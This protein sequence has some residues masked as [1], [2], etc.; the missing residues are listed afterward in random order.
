MP[1]ASVEGKCGCGAMIR[2]SAGWQ[3]GYAADCNSAY[4]GSIPTPASNPH[5][6]LG[7]SAA[8]QRIA[9]ATTTRPLVL[10]E[11]VSV[12]SPAGSSN[13]PRSF[14]PTTAEEASNS[15]SRATSP[16][17]E[18]EVVGAEAGVGTA[19]RAEAERLV[20]AAHVGQVVGPAA[21]VPPQAAWRRTP[22]SHCRRHWGCGPWCG[23]TCPRFRAALGG[24]RPGFGTSLC[25]IRASLGRCLRRPAVDWCRRGGRHRSIARGRWR[26]RAR[27]RPRRCRVPASAPKR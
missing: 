23:D 16:G 26:S 25:R 15:T 13:S 5:F 6:R 4:A 18:L 2:G 3:S 22:R 7:S 8:R 1:F 21:N 11:T 19:A 24:S 17:G 9:S 12:T 14:Q 27:D 10:L 20:R